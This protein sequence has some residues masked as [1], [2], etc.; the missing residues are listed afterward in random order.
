M[1]TGSTDCADG[2]GC[3]RCAD[4]TVALGAD[5]DGCTGCADVTTKDCFSS[6]LKK[7]WSDARLW[8]FL[9]WDVSQQD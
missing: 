9:S 7:K 2:D 4:G 6:V 8:N 1:G 5:G 3:T